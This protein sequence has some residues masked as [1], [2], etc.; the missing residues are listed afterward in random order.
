MLAG[1]WGLHAPMIV[2]RMRRTLLLTAD[3]AEESRAPSV[4]VM[5]RRRTLAANATPSTL[6][7]STSSRSVPTTSPCTSASAPMC[8]HA[9]DSSRSIIALAES[10]A[11]ASRGLA[12]P[13]WLHLCSDCCAALLFMK[14]RPGACGACRGV[15]CATTSAWFG[16]PAHAAGAL[17]ASAWEVFSAFEAACAP[18]SWPWIA[19]CAGSPVDMSPTLSGATSDQVACALLPCGDTD[20]CIRL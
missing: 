14:T 2:E 20:D 1:A 5:P 12:E 11:T 17:N 4:S 7:A 10:S 9:N 3:A 19:S 13:Q 16:P 6:P 15:L 8:P 18:I